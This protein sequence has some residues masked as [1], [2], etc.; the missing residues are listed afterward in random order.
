M[1]WSWVVGVG[2]GTLFILFVIAFF[3]A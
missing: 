1:G 2:N 3:Q